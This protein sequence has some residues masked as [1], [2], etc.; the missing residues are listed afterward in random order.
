MVLDF[1]DEVVA[2]GGV[3]G[4]V[5]PGAA[6]VGLYEGRC[7][8]GGDRGGVGELSVEECVVG[9]PDMGDG[10]DGTAFRLRSAKSCSRYW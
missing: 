7:V 8:G 10:A 3:V 4:G 9:L 6:G 5:A 1:F 2:R